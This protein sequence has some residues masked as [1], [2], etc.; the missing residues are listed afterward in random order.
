MI[1]YHELVFLHCIHCHGKNCIHCQEADVVQDAA[2]VPLYSLSDHFSGHTL[3]THK[4]ER[5]VQSLYS[6]QS[7]TLVCRPHP[8]SDTSD[9][10]DVPER[11]LLQLLVLLLY[12]YAFLYLSLGVYPYKNSKSANLK[13]PRMVLKRKSAKN[14]HM[15][16]NQF[17]V[18][19]VCFGCHYIPNII[20]ITHRKRQHKSVWPECVYRILDI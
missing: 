6:Q 16:I 5:R 3:A 15:K 14:K 4:P 12:L 7:P 10:T 20:P 8:G 18:S 9:M 2:T 13:T 17:T 1:T 11:K 19:Q